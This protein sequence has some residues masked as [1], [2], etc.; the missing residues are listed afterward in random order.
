MTLAKYKSELKRIRLCPDATSFADSRALV[1]EMHRVS[2]ERG[3]S[4]VKLG[5]RVESASPASP[6]VSFAIMVVQSPGTPTSS[7]HALATYVWSRQTSS[8]RAAIV[9]FARRKAGAVWRS[10][11]Q[12][13]VHGRPALTFARRIVG[14]DFFQPAG[15][16]GYLR[17]D[18][19]QGSVRYP[20]R[21]KRSGQRWQDA[22]ALENGS[23]WSQLSICQVPPPFP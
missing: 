5:K 17:P 11:R 8:P 18:L 13:D 4:S 6:R 14:A 7:N 22:F 16:V 20:G 9:M 23:L 19:P 3:T 12:T 1:R 21:N 15:E 2:I 10:N